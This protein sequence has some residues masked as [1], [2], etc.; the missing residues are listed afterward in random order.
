MPFYKDFSQFFPICLEGN[1]T[2]LSMKQVK[3]SNVEVRKGK[4]KTI[5]A[6]F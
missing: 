6:Y 2:D 4:K 3:D 1:L 5:K